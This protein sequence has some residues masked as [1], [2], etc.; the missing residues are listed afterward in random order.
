MQIIFSGPLGSF[1]S[2]QLLENRVPLKPVLEGVA[3]DSHI[4]TGH[5][6]TQ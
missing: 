5:E 4:I 3:G 1:C 6:Q 2:F